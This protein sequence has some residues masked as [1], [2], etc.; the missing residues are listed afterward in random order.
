M[1][2]LRTTDLQHL[3]W[4]GKS[5]EHGKTE[6]AGVEG[7]SSL[8]KVKLEKRIREK[9][10][11]MKIKNILKNKYIGEVLG[12]AILILSV[13]ALTLGPAFIREHAVIMIVLLIVIL[14]ISGATA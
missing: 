4:A 2:K 13:L 14:V 5:H 9:A 8:L 10:R 11:T 6:N 1:Q 12:V 7:L 3:L